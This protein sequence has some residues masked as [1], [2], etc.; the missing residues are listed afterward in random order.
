MN[1]NLVT[2]A[3]AD[4]LGNVISVSKNNPE[5]GYVRVQQVVAGFTPDGWAR[6][7][8]RSALLK[9]KI[10]ELKAFNFKA[11]QTLNGKIVVK[12]AFTP[13][14]NEFPEKDLKLAG[15]TGIVCR[16][17]DQPIYRQTF[18]TQDMNAQDE[19]IM[20]NNTDEIREAQAIANETQKLTG[21]VT[22]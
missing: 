9:G 12:E 17:D 4:E 16:V 18:F 2:V 5:Y 7:Q 1:N 22:L 3:A 13:F 20:H 15:T 19:L 14:N 6:V 21:K 11:G 10:D 8:T